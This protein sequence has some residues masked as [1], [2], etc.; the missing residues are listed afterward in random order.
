M[1]LH[2]SD[3]ILKTISNGNLYFVEATFCTFF[4]FAALSI[5]KL[6]LDPEIN[7][8]GLQAY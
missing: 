4:S 6:Y 8:L 7:N 2:G 3:Y 5:V 1:F